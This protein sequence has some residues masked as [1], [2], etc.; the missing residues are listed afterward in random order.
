MAVR[1]S[2][3][4]KNPADFTKFEFKQLVSARVDAVIKY[5]VISISISILLSDLML[6]AHPRSP[7]SNSW[8]RN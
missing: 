8:V 4:P 7:W 5:L 6:T 3:W 2:W 1:G